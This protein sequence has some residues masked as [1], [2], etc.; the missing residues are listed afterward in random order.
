MRQLDERDAGVSD[1]A[2]STP[3]DSQNLADC[4]TLRITGNDYETLRSHLIRSNGKEYA[5]YL[6][7]GTQTYEKD[8]DRILEYLVRDVVTIPPFR[9][10]DH[11]SGYVG[12]PH[13]VTHEMMQDAK[14]DDARSDEQAVLVAHSH[15]WSTN[16]A[17]SPLDD[18]AEPKQLATIT[19]SRAGP[20]GSIIVGPE[21]DS[22]TG[23]VWPD[24]AGTVRDGDT[25]V[26]TPIDEV[27]VLDEFMQRRFSTTDS[28]L[29]DAR[30]SV[31]DSEMHDRQALLHDEE[32]NAALA[33]ADVTVVGAGGLGSELIKHLAHL[34]VGRGDGSITVIDPD[35][36]EESNRSRIVGSRPS[37]A[38]REDATPDEDTVVPAQWTDDID[39]LGMAKVDVAARYIRETDPAITV[40]PIREVAQV[41]EGIDAITTADVVL[42]A[43]DQHTVRR[44]VSR[45]CSQYLRPLVD[46]GVAIDTEDATSIASRVTVSGAGRPCL[47]C[48]GAINDT[49]LNREQHGD[50]HEAEYGVGEQPAVM[51]VNAEAAQRAAF[52][53][54]RYLT[55]L[56]S[57]TEAPFDTGVRDMV[58]NRTVPHRAESE[59]T[60]QF[61]GENALFPARG[62]RAPTPAKD[63]TRTVP[64]LVNSEHEKERSERSDH[65]P[66]SQRMNRS[67]IEKGTRVIRDMVG[68]LT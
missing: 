44:I 27:V 63:P 29:D 17:H 28:R 7:A 53:V 57:D 18:D 52:I 59:D 4:V 19:H 66:R 51:P 48:A 5:A 46:A 25:S 9:Y 55:G 35:V 26:A 31:G 49:R 16:P 34:G 32:G 8:G 40:R 23:R 2:T 30:R 64:S 20:H 11:Q 62:D 43:P 50:E 67:L 10:T 39:G 15:P 41:E 56:L 38:G 14:P 61:C 45:T 68:L 54:H 13:D 3:E 22:I 6:L 24:D 42:S 47:D 65:T 12:I 37:D 60:C 33:D 58:S 36:V 1:W 21:D